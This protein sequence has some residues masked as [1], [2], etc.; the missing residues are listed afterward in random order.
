MNRELNIILSKANRH[1]PLNDEEFAFAK[2][3]EES[4]DAEEKIMAHL[5]I[6]YIGD[7]EERRAARRKLIAVCDGWLIPCGTERDLQAAPRL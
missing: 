4:Q 6:L 5:V 1:I 2:G 7:L 3:K